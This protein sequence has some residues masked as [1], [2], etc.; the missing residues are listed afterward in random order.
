MAMPNQIMISVP[1]SQL[2]ADWIRKQTSKGAIF[3][4]SVIQVI[5]GVLA[6]FSEMHREYFTICMGI[7]TGLT[8]GINGVI[9][10]FVANKPSKCKLT[11]LYIMS[12]ISIVFSLILICFWIIIFMYGWSIIGIIQFITGLFETG[13]AI[14]TAVLSCNVICCRR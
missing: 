7:W 8:F 9:G 1:Q 5:C 6:V 4:L 3:A 13:S 11:A 10:L 2:E 14:G 12:I